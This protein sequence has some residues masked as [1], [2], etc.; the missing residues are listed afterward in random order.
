MVGDIEI[1]ARLDIDGDGQISR[2]EL[3]QRVAEFV[4]SEDERAAGNWLYGEF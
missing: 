1:F 2:D 3:A 4:A